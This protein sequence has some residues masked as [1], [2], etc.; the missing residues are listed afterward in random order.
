[1]QKPDSW[2]SFLKN[3]L[4]NRLEANPRY[5]LRAFARDLALSPGELSELLNGKRS[6][7][8]KALSKIV[9]RL[10]LSEAETKNLVF[11]AHLE[12]TGAD[13][14]SQ[15]VTTLNETQ[16]SM[17]SEWYYF[18][19]LNFLHLN[20]SCVTILTMA[21]RLG[22]K[23]YQV[24]LAIEKLKE[25]GLV[26]QKGEKIQLNEKA[27]SSPRET[28]SRDIKKFHKQMLEKASHALELQEVSERHYEG[29]T[30]PLDKNLLPEMKNEISEFIEKLLHKYAR[31]KKRSEVYHLELALFRLTEKE[32]I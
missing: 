9:S 23:F 1:M 24:K 13:F 26:K 18:A 2:K 32:K 30:L 21:R 3:E 27:V 16:F 19:I 20:A 22:L 6:L 4:S 12:K 31:G 17:L 15:E 25:V 7:S 29:I 11:M 10:G 8:P 5:S 28:P 14:S